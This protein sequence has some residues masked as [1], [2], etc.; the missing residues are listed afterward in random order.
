[1]KKIEQEFNKII[2]I[3]MTFSLIFSLFGLFLVLKNETSN[4]IVGLIIG[5]FFLTHACI[6][7]FSFINKSKISLFKY[8]LIYGIL[9][10][11]LGIFIMIDPFSLKEI[12]NISL[13]IWILLNG[14]IKYWYFIK[15]KELDKKIGSLLLISSIS[16]I[17][18]SIVLLLNLLQNIVITTTVGVFII[19]SNIL[20]LNDLV[21][22]KKKKNKIKKIFE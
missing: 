11:I 22:L 6:S 1:M 9:Y 18:L 3:E 21:L 15:I 13:G 17:I 10:I 2:L 8:N 14:V 12:L 16:L 5:V 4:K 7:I 20:N 19:L